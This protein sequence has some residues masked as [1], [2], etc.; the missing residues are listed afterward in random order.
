MDVSVEFVLEDAED[1][2]L[3]Y[4]FWYSVDNGLIW[5]EASISPGDGL[6]GRVVSPSRDRSVNGLNTISHK[7]RSS[8]LRL[9]TLSSSDTLNVVW[10]SGDDIPNIDSDQVR[11]MITVEDN[12]AGI[13][14]T[15]ET[16][17]VDN[18]QSHSILLSPIVEEQVDSVVIAF[19]LIDTTGDDLSILFEYSSNEGDTWMVCSLVGDTSGLGV[20]QYDGSVVWLSLEDLPGVDLQSVWLRSMPYDNWSSGIGDTILFHLDNNAPPVVTVDNVLSEQSGDVDI[21]YSL[22][23]AE[24]DEVTYG[25]YYS[26]DGGM[27]WVDAAFE[28]VIP[29]SV[30]R[31]HSEEDLPLSDQTDIQFKVSP[32]D[33]DMGISDS[34][35][36]FHLDN[37]HLHTVAM[38]DI[39]GEQSG[40]VEIG[41]LVSDS[42]GD[43]IDLSFYYSV[44]SGVSWDLIDTLSAISEVGYDGSY[45]WDSEI[46]LDGE[47]V[48]DLR[49]A[50]VSTDGWQIGGSDTISFHLDNE[51][52]PQLIYAQE[53]VYP[54]PQ[55]PIEVKFD[56]PMD[57]NSIE[58]NIT[59]SSMNVADLGTI[60]YIYLSQ[61]N[62]V[63]IF[64]QDG[65]PSSDTLEVIL[66]NDLRDTFGK[67]FDGNQDGDPQFSSVDDS[68]L[69]VH[70]FTTGDFD[71]DGLM[72]QSD[73]DLFTSGWWSNDPEKETGPAQ[74]EI[75]HLV[76]QPDGMFDI[77]DLMTFVRFWD[78][79]ASQGFLSTSFDGTL[80]DNRLITDWDGHN[81]KLGLQSVDNISGV[82]FMI[83][84]DSTLVNELRLVKILHQNVDRIQVLHFTHKEEINATHHF[85]G[86]LQQIGAGEDTTWFLSLPLEL[87]VNRIVELK[88]T[89]EY[90]I[91]DISYTGSSVLRL[92]PVPDNFALHQNYPNPFNPT[93]TLR[94]DL[95]GQS[96]VKLLIYDILGREV[97]ELVKCTQ[98]AGYKSVIWDGT[99]DQGK[100]VSAGMYL[101]RISTGDYHAV[102]KMILLK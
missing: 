53:D 65:I 91:S 6:A 46:Q 54:L 69:L 3:T 55:N 15:T 77:E 52:G 38:D 90:K 92:E 28:V 4:A 87:E 72:G 98:D 61:N 34:T 62:S 85:L 50:V 32:F 40:D 25:Y 58:G 21:S 75:P 11:F 2:V 22:Y 7:L 97:K 102:K 100:N 47:D 45:L 51:T 17:T 19:S 64:L 70:S 10:H 67:G 79:S 71:L 49:L 44:D 88:V 14:D 80:N 84:H 68:T 82:H 31:W 57:P 5:S 18:F 78:Y 56:R 35:A 101:Y 36:N 89:Y 93:T 29:D 81:L 1:D 96:H 20:G 43:A 94:Y 41:Y 63:Q 13:P 59:I 48:F 9:R 42:T 95:P 30:V 39:V 26:E 27:S 16:F 60:E 12:D 74:G 66:Y 24:S 33:N 83:N 73:I 23:D 99:N 8:I 76:V 86:F 37:W